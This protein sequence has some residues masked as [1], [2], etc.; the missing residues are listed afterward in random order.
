MATYPVINKN[1]GEQKDVVMSVHEWS[2]W[3]ADN[4]DWQRDWVIHL[5]VRSLVKSVNGK[6]NF[7][8]NTLVG[9]T[10]LPKSIKP[11]V[12]TRRSKYARKEK[13]E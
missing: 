9:M 1:T 10:F 7:V 12:L 4:P 5:L 11:Q 2:Q 13:K 8:K 6:I 3:C